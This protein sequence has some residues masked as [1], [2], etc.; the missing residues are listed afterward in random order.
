MTPLNYVQVQNDFPNAW[1]EVP[2]CYRN[3]SCLSF[4]LSDDGW[5]YVEPKEGEEQ[6]LGS[7]LYYWSVEHDCWFDSVTN[8]QLAD[9]DEY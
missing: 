7:W 1:L 5:L 6:A 9:A 3:D 2:T 4:F 8:Q